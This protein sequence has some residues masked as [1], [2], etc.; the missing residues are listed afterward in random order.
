[1]GLRKTLLRLFLGSGR[2]EAIS[3][4]RISRSPDRG[5]LVRDYLPAFAAEGGRIL[6]VGCRPYTADY[7]AALEAHGAEVWTTDIE[8]RAEAW[9]RAGRHRTGDIGDAGRLFGD[10]QFDA[11]LCNGVLGWGV[12]SAQDQ[13]RALAAMADILKSGGRLLLGWNTDKMADPIAAGLAAPHFEPAPFG[14][15]P[16]RLAVPEVTHVYDLLVRRGR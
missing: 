8:D 13:A 4:A 1:M 11:V 2:A 6:W 12:D 7:Y 10:L 16:A 15:L 9:G 3:T 5:F 14:P